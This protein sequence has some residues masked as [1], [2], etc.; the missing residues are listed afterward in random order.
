MK[1]IAL[2]LFCSFSAVVLASDDDSQRAGTVGQRPIGD[3]RKDVKAFVKR[4][5]LADDPVASVGAIIDLCHL[6]TEIVND[7]RFATNR[8]LQSFRAVAASRLKKYVKEI[9]LE[10]KR[11]K[12][13]ADLEAKQADRATSTA[14]QAG[15]PGNQEAT[16][17]GDRVATARNPEPNMERHPFPSS[18][19]G[20]DPE[21]ALSDSMARDA[22]AMSTFGGG[23]VQV[24][25]YVGGNFAPPWDHGPELVALIESTI[26]PQS[27]KSRGG[28]GVI[29]Y[30]R[31][32]RILVVSASS[33]VQDDVS[34]ML[35]NLRRLSR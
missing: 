29:H 5:K 17:T 22:Y 34:N 23:P 7:P 19:Q 26:D 11:R 6:H 1:L 24:W 33:S 8:Q 28:N 12:R 30:Y 16:F 32:L 35:R 14:P 20:T 21:V 18:G 9:E 4:S 25:T 15:E 2:I 13:R 27:W 3:L 10:I 31:P